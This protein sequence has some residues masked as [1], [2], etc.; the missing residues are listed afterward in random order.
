MKNNLGSSAM[1]VLALSATVCVSPAIAATQYYGGY[2]YTY[3]LING[4]AEAEIYKASMTPALSPT[5]SGSVT[6]PSALGGKPVTSIGHSALYSCPS[7]Y[8]VTIPASVKNIG[9]STF[10]MCTGLTAVNFAAPSSL[11]NVGTSAFYNCKKLPSITLPDSVV[12]IQNNAFNACELLTSF[13]LPPLVAALNDTTFSY[14]GLSSFTIPTNITAVG[15]SVFG[16]STNL[17]S[18]TFTSPSQ[19]KTIGQWAF[20]SCDALQEI[21]LPNTVTNIGT[22]AF[23]YC[24]GLSAVTLSAS[25]TALPNEL[26]SSC[27]NLSEVTIPPTVT[28]I[29]ASTFSACLSLKSITIPASV[30]TIGVNGFYNCS[31]MTAVVFSASSGLTTI[32]SYGFDKCSA[33][34]SVKLPGSVATIGESAFRYCSAMASIEIP[35][36]VTYLWKEAFRYCSALSSVTF[37]GNAPTSLGTSIYANTPALTTYVPVGSTGWGVS[38]PGTWQLKAIRYFVSVSF[39]AQGGDATPPS[40]N[41]GVGLAYGTLPGVTRSGYVFGGWFT[42][43][44]GVGAEI[45][46]STTVT[47]TSPHTLYAKW[48]VETVTVV[49]GGEPVT[50]PVSTNF[51]ANVTQEQVDAALTV[52]TNRYPEITAQAVA[53]LSSVA[54]ALGVTMELLA[55]ETN[56]VLFTPKLVIEEAHVANG[57]AAGTDFSLSFT[58]ENGITDTAV[59]MQLLQQ[60]VSKRIQVTAMSFLSDT[61]T[62]VNP[63]LEFVGGKCIVSFSLESPLDSAFFKIRISNSN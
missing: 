38:I 28:S 6:L 11:T 1:F 43:P 7:L 9:P 63:T 49:I 53:E 22:G 50:Q 25:L 36:S 14:S 56:I 37:Y 21:A 58:V 41:V 47:A 23:R 8:S 20:E 2:T 32:G 5:P 57:S 39:D 48:T 31:A 10:A 33:V 17:T 34:T 3:Q 40:R 54:D 30:T 51:M 26:F 62:L 59:A 19:V 45:T 13:T 61:G 52:L 18:V 46:S 60:S 35:A 27:R 55:T 4:G 42:Q 12:S 16:N 15:F 44:N 29:G 24:Y